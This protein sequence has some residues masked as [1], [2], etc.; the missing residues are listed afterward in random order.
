MTSDGKLGFDALN[1]A[2]KAA[3]EETRLR[4]LALLAEAELTVSDLTDILRRSQRRTS[5]RLKLR[6][7]AGMV[8]RLR[9]GTWAFSRLADHGSGADVARALIARLNPA[10][11]IITR[12]RARLASVRQARAAAAQAYF[13]AHAAEWDRIR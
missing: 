5:R 11:Q 10:D 3:G 12:D 6:G 13:R 9:Q 1:S 7:E 4:V 2:L 8:E